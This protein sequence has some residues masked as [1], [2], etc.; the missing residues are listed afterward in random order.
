MKSEAS[1]PSSTRRYSE[2][3]EKE[4]AVE[5]GTTFRKSVTINRP[6]EELY[7]FWRNFQNFPRFMVNL[8]DVT[9]IDSKTSH[10]KVAGPADTLYE[11]D[12]V[13]IRDI[14]GELISWR[15]TKETDVKNAGSVSFREAPGGRGTVVTVSL[16]YNPPGGAVGHWIAMLF[17][18]DPGQQVARNLNRFKALMET[19]EIPTSDLTPTLE[20]A[21]ALLGAL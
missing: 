11:W 20:S 17:G 9:L 7:Q 5:G 10:W 16:D 12:A 21:S 13:I 14:P 19:G 6:R 3:V 2:N 4:N 8:R 1:T 18:K 15:A